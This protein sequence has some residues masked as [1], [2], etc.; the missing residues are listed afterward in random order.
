MSQENVEMVRRGLE[1]FNRGDLDEALEMYDP[2]VEVKTLLSGSAN[3]REEV[4]AVILDREKEMGAVQYVPKD[5]IDAG[6]TIVGVVR[7]AGT[8]RFSGISD[9]DFP[10]G[11]QLAFVWTFQTALSFDRRCSAPRMKPSKPP[12]CGSSTASPVRTATAQ[13]GNGW[14]S[15][16]RFRPS[17]SSDA[18]Y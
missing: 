9:T 11:Q 5:L 1:A 7:A 12:G 2:Q 15:P 17:P 13:V 16:V 10:A 6:D 4:R 8:G 18:R 14:A 3:G